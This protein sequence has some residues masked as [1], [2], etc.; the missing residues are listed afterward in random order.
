V[1]TLA[2]AVGELT[3]SSNGHSQHRI[4]ERRSSV[5]GPVI[6]T[7]FHHSPIRHRRSQSYLA[8]P[9]PLASVGD[10]ASTV[11]V[12]PAAAVKVVCNYS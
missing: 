5:S 12:G 6:G 7:S 1:G 11:V 10:Q 3:V 2:R 9:L 4:S 8:T